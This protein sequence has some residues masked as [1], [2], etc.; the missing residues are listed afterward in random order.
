MK[1]VSLIAALSVVVGLVALTATGAWL[2]SATGIARG[3]AEGRAEPEPPP[4]EEQ[5]WP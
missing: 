5:L 4:A 3:A 2:I 1:L